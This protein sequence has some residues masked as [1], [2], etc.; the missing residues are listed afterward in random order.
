MPLCSISSIYHSVQIVR[1]RA[2]ITSQWTQ[3]I[4]WGHIFQTHGY[5]FPLCAAKIHLTLLEEQLTISMSGSGGPSDRLQPQTT[6]KNHNNDRVVINCRYANMRTTPFLN[7]TSS[8]V[9]TPVSLNLD[10]CKQRGRFYTNTYWTYL[11][12]SEIGYWAFNTSEQ[13]W[14]V[15]KKIYFKYF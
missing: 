11:G 3:F 8:G 6:E 2:Q 10:S 5:S 9:M 12:G 13:L 15:E 14:L 4:H 1:L 7:L